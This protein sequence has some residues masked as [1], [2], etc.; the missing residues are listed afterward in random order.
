MQVSYK[1]TNVSG[2]EMFGVAPGG[3]YIADGFF[4]REDPA[5][6]AEPF[7]Y[8]MS[9]VFTYEGSYYCI[10]ASRQYDIGFLEPPAVRL[11]YQLVSQDNSRGTKTYA[12]TVTNASEGKIEDFFLS[13]DYAMLMLED[14][15]FES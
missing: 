7:E 10:L 11:E 12:F 8:N 3:D 13:T 9:F 15:T 2:Q 4:Q 1:Y 5:D 14:G 6:E